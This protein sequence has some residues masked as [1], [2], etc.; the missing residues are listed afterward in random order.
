MNETTASLLP[1]E[2]E[3]L[4]S[5]A[6]FKQPPNLPQI[7]EKLGFSTNAGQIKLSY[8]VDHLEQ[9]GFMKYNRAWLHTHVFRDETL[10]WNL[11]P[12]GRA[13]VQREQQPG[14]SLS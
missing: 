14:F 4:R 11:T 6:S 8:Y 13:Y 2:Q 10:G 12:K 5:L 7:A 3:I 9:D 1:I